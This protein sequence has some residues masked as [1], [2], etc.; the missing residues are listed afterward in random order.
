MP[1][2]ASS[3]IETGQLPPAGARH[4]CDRFRPGGA[5]LFAGIGEDANDPTEASCGETSAP[6]IL[7]P[8]DDNGRQGVDSLKLDVERFRHV[9]GR[10]AGAG[11]LA[12]PKA[13][14]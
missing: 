10:S 8:L 13:R 12:Q 14:G 7:K 4:P 2:R 1:V 5:G 9:Q 11:I 3:R 6:D